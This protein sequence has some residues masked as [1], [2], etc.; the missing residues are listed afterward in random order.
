MG[1]PYMGTTTWIEDERAPGGAA[2]GA[3]DV[4]EEEEDAPFRFVSASEIAADVAA[5][6]FERLTSRPPHWSPESFR[7]HEYEPRHHGSC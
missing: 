5:G 3:N 2:W 1:I 6:D 4:D 7:S